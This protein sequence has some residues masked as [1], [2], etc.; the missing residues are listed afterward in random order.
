M[1]KSFLTIVLFPKDVPKG[2]SNHSLSLIA[3][4]MIWSYGYS[5]NQNPLLLMREEIIVRINIKGQN[6]FKT[7]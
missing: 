4:K 5:V 2:S 1:Q 6:I 3:C 7:P